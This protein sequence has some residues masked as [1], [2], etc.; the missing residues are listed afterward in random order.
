MFAAPII[1]WW[2]SAWEIHRP[3]RWSLGRARQPIAGGADTSRP[4]QKNS[5]LKSRLYAA[6]QRDATNTRPQH[7]AIVLAGCASVRASGLA[8]KKRLRGRS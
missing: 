3:Y 6:T 8:A 5:T 4:R 2:S 7:W 1:R